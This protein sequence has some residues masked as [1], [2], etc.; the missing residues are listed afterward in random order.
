M[1]P[2]ATNVLTIVFLL[3]ATIFAFYAMPR[4]RTKTAVNALMFRLDVAHHSIP[5]QFAYAY[6]V[7]G[8]HLGD[9]ALEI[10]YHC[11]SAG[12]QAER[13]LVREILTLRGNW[14]EDVA[15][16]MAITEWTDWSRSPMGR[17]V[18]GPIARVK[19]GAGATAVAGDL[20][21][22]SEAEWLE[23]GNDLALLAD[24]KGSSGIRVYHLK[25]RR[26]HGLCGRPP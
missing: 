24:R 20:A 12:A 9:G 7:E 11:T 23:L 22:E 2:R 1:M 10:H 8:T 16:V 21:L 6:T 15:R 19:L 13:S 14:P 17:P 25:L 5:P 18:G 26:T 4:L 3:V